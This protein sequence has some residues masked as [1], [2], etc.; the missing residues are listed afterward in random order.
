M[1]KQKSADV[2]GQAVVA[3]IYNA[4]CPKTHH[5]SWS[6]NRL[7]ATFCPSGSDICKDTALQLSIQIYKGEISTS[8]Y[9]ACLLYI[10]KALYYMNLKKDPYSNI[11]ICITMIHLN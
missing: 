7:E 4:V 1:D 8:M 6:I 9:L 2:Q 3:Y 11:Y 10:T 5:S